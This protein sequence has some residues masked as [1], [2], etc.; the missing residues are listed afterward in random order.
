M[1][2]LT[3]GTLRRMVDE[4]LSV[5]AGDRQH[6]GACRRCQIRLE[7]I[8]TS[9]RQAAR[10]LAVSETPIDPA[11]ALAHVRQRLAAGGIEPPRGW[12][13][14]LLARIEPHRRQLVKPVGGVALAA[15][16]LGALSLTPAGSFAQSLIT[17]FQPTQVAAVP[18]ATGDLR[19]LPELTKFGTI[20]APKRV[21]DH[22]VGSAV[23]A[24][25]VSGM[26]VLTPQSLPGGVPSAV[27]YDVIP[28]ATGT[29]TFS[30]T[31]ARRAAAAAGKAL[32]PMPARIDGSTLQLTT[33]TAVI[34]VYGGGKGDALPAL[35]IG[36][37]KAPRVSSTGVSVKQI[38]DYVLSL[39]GVSPQ[40]AA[41]IRSIG[42][43]TTTLPIPIPIDQAQSQSVQ[44]Q[45][46]NGVAVGD[47][48]GLGSVVIWE[49]NG[50]IYGVG[51][52]LSEDQVVALAN[53]LQ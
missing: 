9:A 42:D 33:G 10:L 7:K 1:R 48:T 32:P 30:A 52:T 28:G 36:Q 12:K 17:I 24:A 31:R 43:P 25:S 38:E 49:K 15:G 5:S 20:H 51:G 37:M 16:L 53:S 6:S 47:A 45:G 29:F 14:R 3:D 4:P 46:V 35:V 34:A 21:H 18:I 2:H 8:S 41:S 23:A 13:A 22:P 26:Q 27:T 40:L 11:L 19:N 44:V 50:I 39:P